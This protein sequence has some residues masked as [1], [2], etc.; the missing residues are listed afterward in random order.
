VEEEDD[1]GSW[2]DEEDPRAGFSEEEDDDLDWR[3]SSSRT[4]ALE[5]DEEDNE[6]K[7]DKEEAVEDG[8]RECEGVAVLWDDE[9]EATIRPDG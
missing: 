3:L 8:E 4:L 2:L 6:D 1:E 7:E 5:A 9:V